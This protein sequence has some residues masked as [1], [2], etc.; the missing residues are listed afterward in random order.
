LAACPGIAFSIPNWK[1]YAGHVGLVLFVI[2][3]LTTLKIVVIFGVE[4]L[5]SSCFLGVLKIIL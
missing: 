3:K 1:H 4:G 5:A 2:L